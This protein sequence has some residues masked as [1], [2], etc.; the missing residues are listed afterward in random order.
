VNDRFE[1]PKYLCRTSSAG[2]I[3]WK[4]T[5]LGAWVDGS[6]TQA[7]VADGQL[8]RLARQSEACVVP[9]LGFK[10][11]FSAMP[12]L[13][14]VRL[15]TTSADER[16]MQMLARYVAAAAG[17]ALSAHE[18]SQALQRLEHMVAAN[19]DEACGGGERVHNVIR[20]AGPLHHAH[21]ASYGDGRLAPAE[22]VRTATG[23][24]WKTDFFGHVADHTIVGKQSVLWDVAGVLVEWGFGGC[25]RV[26]FL[27]ALVSAGIRPVAALLT[28]YELAY[29]AFRLGQ[30]RLCRDVARADSGE[31]RRLDGAQKYYQQRCETIL[32]ASV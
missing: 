29:A 15:D 2:A 27:N 4:F 32:Q 9:V 6:L 11:G 22:W 3:V 25:Q 30:T 12:W 8:R 31:R 28:F 14:G 7:Q 17:P 21:P 20:A 5:G 23:Q 19:V 24:L 1:R 18:H 16:V 13:D 10:L 26:C